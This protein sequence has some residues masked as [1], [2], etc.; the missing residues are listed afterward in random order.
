MWAKNFYKRFFKIILL[1][2][3][4]RLSKIRLVHTYGVRQ[5]H[6]F[7]GQCSN[8]STTKY[9]IIQYILGTNSF[10]VLFLRK[11]TDNTEVAFSR[12]IRKISF[13]RV[14]CHHCIPKVAKYYIKHDLLI[15]RVCILFFEISALLRTP[16]ILFGQACE[17]YLY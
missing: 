10:G 17:A 2:I 14:Q 9:F 7:A 13:V 5:I 6:V 15:F 1:Y 11:Y 8:N 3:N 16:T 12:L 4:G